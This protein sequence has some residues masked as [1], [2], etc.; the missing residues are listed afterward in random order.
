LEEEEPMNLGLLIAL[1]AILGTSSM[2]G[3][4]LSQLNLDALAGHKFTNGVIFGMAEFI[5]LIFSGVTIAKFSDIITW[6]SNAI[7]TVVSTMCLII[8]T[9]YENSGHEI[10]NVVFTTGIFASTF[11]LA[12]MNNTIFIMVETRT[13]A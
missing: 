13:P 10:N 12:S 5:A 7:L 2:Q 8:F 9:Y 3:Y 4:T 1:L 6:R 11:G